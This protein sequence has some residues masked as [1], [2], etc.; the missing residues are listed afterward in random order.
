MKIAIFD[1]IVSDNIPI[2]GC[3]RTLLKHLAE[4]HDFTVYASEFDNPDPERIRFVRVP[5]VKKPLFIFFITYLISSLFLRKKVR[6]ENELIAGAENY[7]FFPELAYVHF[8]HRAFLMLQGALLIRSGAR[9]WF[10]WLDHAMRAQLE[11]TVYRRARLI[12]TPSAG[13]KKELIRTYPDLRGKIR[14][15]PNPID[16]ERMAD[17]P[18][19]D[20]KATRLGA[21]FSE[22]DL[23]ISFAA[24]GHFERKGLP[25]VLEALRDLNK[26]RLK[27][28]VIGGDPELVAHY[29]RRAVSLGIKESVCFVGAQK[30]IRPFLLSSDAFVFPSSYETFSLVVHEAAAAGLPIISSDIYGVQDWLK[31]GVNGI[32]VERTV[33]S[34]MDA[35]ER[36]CSM[37]ETDRIAMGCMAQQSVKRFSIEAFVENWRKLYLELEKS[38]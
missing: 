26:P 3:H 25:L 38:Q 7:C 10:R 5:S 35:M 31:N 27:L 17:L 8:C 19:F 32:A 2:G 21:G 33:G 36:L 18:G 13:L 16:A 9:G 34:L 12:V 37:A 14:V 29:E 1:Y 22:Q 23:V 30:D 28:L 15:I 24:L 6:V 20:R 4:E 11:R